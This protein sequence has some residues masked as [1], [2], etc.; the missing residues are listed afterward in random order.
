MCGIFSVFFCNYLQRVQ[1]KGKRVALI[2][3]VGRTE[4]I[5]TKY[6]NTAK[7]TTKIPTKITVK[8]SLKST[9]KKI[10]TNIN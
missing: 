8:S 9:T 5:N 2:K 4:N 3:L 6:Q 10:Y 7:N 1:K